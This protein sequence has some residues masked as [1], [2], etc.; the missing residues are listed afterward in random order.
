MARARPGASAINWLMG[1]NTDG[2]LYGYF[3]GAGGYSTSGGTI[4]AGTWNHALWTVRNIGGVYTGSVWLNAVQVGGNIVAG[5]MTDAT[6][7]AKIG[8]GGSS[9]TAPNPFNGNIDEVT[10]WNVGMTSAQITALYNANKPNDPTTHSLVANLTHLYRMGDDDT[11]PTILDKVGV[12]NGTCTNM[13]SGV[14]N[15]VAVVP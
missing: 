10:I 6:S 4:V 1:V 3:G 8:A 13:T 14:V 15:F 7:Q 12:F 11:Y 9:S 5:N 2:T